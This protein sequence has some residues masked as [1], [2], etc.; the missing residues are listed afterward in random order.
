MNDFNSK[1]NFQQ[2]DNCDYVECKRINYFDIIK[3]LVGLILMRFAVVNINCYK[4]S[5][6]IRTLSASFNCF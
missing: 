4:A 1:K 6:F 2:S 5:V 3:R